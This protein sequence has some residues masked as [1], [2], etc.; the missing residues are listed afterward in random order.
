MEQLIKPKKSRAKKMKYY[1]SRT[2]DEIIVQY[3]GSID[4]EEREQLYRTHLQKPM[5][6]LAENIINRFKFVYMDGSFEEV[7]QQVIGFLIT[8]LH[9]YNSN[10]GK[11]FSYLSIIAKNY[12][13][14]H[15][16]AG[17]K[18]QLRSIYFSDVVDD[19]NT[20]LEE[21]LE[22]HAPEIDAHE[23]A[24]EFV[25]IFIQYWNAHVEEIF[26]KEKDQK[27]ARAVVYLFSQAETIENYHRKAL[28]LMLRDMTGCK[29]SAITKVV[30]KMK[31]HV[32]DQLAQF[33]QSGRID[34]AELLDSE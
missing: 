3:N 26:V 1:W 8:N 31:D 14:L 13:I 24:K 30:A 17:Y 18:H 12:L 10:K 29:T 15:N 33:N 25:K 6:K 34:E 9:K 23:D 4:F 5:D 22:L 32:I 28:F 2:L 16:T 19:D 7:K 11:S 20:S 27:I 21:T